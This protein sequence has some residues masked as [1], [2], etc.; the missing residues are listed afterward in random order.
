[1]D[2]NRSVVVHILRIGVHGGMLFSRLDAE[3][4]TEATGKKKVGI[5]NEY[6]ADAPYRNKTTL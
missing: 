3:N 4:R 2:V 5:R 6:G 1:M